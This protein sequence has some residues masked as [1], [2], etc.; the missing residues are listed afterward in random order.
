MKIKLN[1]PSVYEC[2]GVTLMP[3][4]ND[5]KNADKFLANKI[6]QAD[7]AAGIVTVEKRGRPAMPKADDE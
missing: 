2:E 4:D 6:V 3:G 5:V 7:I 1:R